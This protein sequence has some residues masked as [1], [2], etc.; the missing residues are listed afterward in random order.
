MGFVFCGRSVIKKDSRFKL[1]EAGDA[2]L[3]KPPEPKWSSDENNYDDSDWTDE[4]GDTGNPSKCQ[5]DT[6]RCP[7]TWTVDYLPTTEQEDWDEENWDTEPEWRVP[8]REEDHASEVC[9]DSVEEQDKYWGNIYPE[10]TE[11]DEEEQRDNEDK[12]ESQSYKAGAL[13]YTYG[14]NWRAGGAQPL[15]SDEDW[16]V[17]C[18]GDDDDGIYWITTT[19]NEVDAT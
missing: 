11:A 19:E 8:E 6:T 2:I 5:N 15:S 3:W 7:D 1:N 13:S 16:D 12:S 18:Q 4:L 17:G 14:R 10:T 9:W